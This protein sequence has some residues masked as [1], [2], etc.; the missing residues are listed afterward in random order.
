MTNRSRKGRAAHP[1]VGSHNGIEI[2]VVVWKNNKIVT[3]ASNF[4]GKSLTFSVERYNKTS[5]QHIQIDGPFVVA[6][7]NMNM[8]GV[9]LL[10]C[11]IGH[12]KIKLR[13]DHYSIPLSRADYV[14]YVALVQKNP[15][16]N[17]VY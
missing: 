6:E 2:S 17:G 7:Y 8:G 15:K 16:R 10:D 9:D 11:I 5:K 4:A 3:L 1:Q 12:Y 13:S 14:Q